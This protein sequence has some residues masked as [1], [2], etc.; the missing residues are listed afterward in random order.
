MAAHDTTEIS[1]K[2]HKLISDWQKKNFPELSY[3]EKH[4]KEYYPKQTPFRLISKI[5]KLKS[6]AISIGRFKDNPYFEQ[7]NEMSGNMFFSAQGIIKAQCSTELGSV[8]Q[9]R[10]S[11]DTAVN[12]DMKFGILRIMA[13]ELRHAYQMFWVL[14]HDPT[15]RRLGMGDVAD[16]M[17]Q[18]LLDMQTGSHVLDAF[19]MQMVSFLDNTV[20]AT[21]IDLVG[22]YQL[23]MQSVFAYAPMARSMGPML[24]EEAFH[25]GHGKKSVRQIAL[26]SANDEGDFSITD[27]QEHLN[28]WLPRG[29]EMFGKEDGGGTNVEFGFKSKTN[30][31]AQDEYYEEARSFVRDWNC[32]LIQQHYLKGTE[33]PDAKEIVEKMWETKDTV[34]GIKPEMIVFVPDKKFCRKRGLEDFVFK[35]Y[36]M[37][38]TLLTGTGG[39]AIGT[40]DY[41]EYLKCV[42][43]E[44]YREDPEFT[45]FG[46]QMK[47]YHDAGGS[48]DVGGAG[49]SG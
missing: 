15:W 26:M 10:V 38:G 27:M 2:Y 30:G 37:H 24:Q 6:E 40:D 36:D 4:W 1:P 29:L 22:K 14:E 48:G 45:R 16:R 34:K 43:P 19:N 12:D 9:H 13:E 28:K 35:P 11:I 46:E 20:F 7:A 32:A 49:Y 42:L 5:G 18:E 31:V 33:Y 25:L 47:E 3:M 39:A 17:I 8:Q 41:M 21:V 23:D 44:D